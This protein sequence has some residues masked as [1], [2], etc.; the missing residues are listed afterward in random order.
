MHITRSTF[1]Y[2][3]ERKRRV[4][5]FVTT[6][7]LT[8]AVCGRHHSKVALTTNPNRIVQWFAR[9]GWRVDTHSRRVIRCPDHNRRNHQRPH[10]AAAHV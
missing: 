9:D 8:C 4:G 7:T 3:L 10:D 5:G 1:A 6:A 2:T